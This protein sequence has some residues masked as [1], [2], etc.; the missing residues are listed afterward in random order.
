[1]SD[2]PT[3]L[4]DLSAVKLALM[5][6]KLRADAQPVLR[7]DPIAVVG[8][9]VRAPG[10]ATDP[11]RLWEVLRTGVDA[12]GDV[13]PD[14]WDAAAWYDPDPAAPGKTITRQG[15]FLPA[16]DGFDAGYFGIVPREA[17]RMDPQ[18]RLVLEI[19]VEAL[20]DAG[21]TR[22]RL[23]GA[24][25][26]VFVA[27]YHN[28]YAQRQY[29]DVEEIDARTLT[30]TLHS[31]L[32]NR[33]SFVL[34]LH[35][36][37]VS[38]DSACSS[39]LVAIHLAC[40]SLRSGET[41]LALAG[42]VS[43]II[44]PEL[45]VSMSKVGFMAPDG[46]C[47]TF[48]ARADGFGRGEGC[49]LVV[50]KRLSDAVADGDRVL[51][52][53]RGSAVNQDGTSTLLAAPNGVAQRALIAEALRN[54]QLDPARIGFV[55]C[56]GTGTALGD[57]LEVE[58]IAA[59]VGA[60]APG[61]GPCWLSATKANVGHL[62]AAAGA[63][64]LVKAVLV[65]RH[66][67]IPQQVHY[68]QLNPHIRLEGTRLAIASE[69]VPWPAGEH[70]RCGGVSSFGV[71]GTNAH[72]VVEEAPRLPGADEPAPD[73]A[74]VL[75]LS[76]HGPE[77]LRALAEAWTGF[78]PGAPDPVADLCFTAAERRTHH[79]LRLA[80]VGRTPDE[81]RARLGE[82][83][84][85]AG[86]GGPGRRSQ[87]AP[88]I[89]FVFSGQGPQWWAMG[90]ELLASEPV[91]RER[92]EA[93]DG[94]LRARTGWSL[95]EELSRDEADSLLGETEIAQPALFALQVALAALWRS[96]GI[97]PAAVVGHSVGEIA[98]LHVAG[99][100]SLP[101]AVRVVAE[102]G[103]I[104][105]AATGLG[106]MAQVALDEAGAAEAV[107]PSG[108][109]LSVAALNGPRSAV[110]SGD[111]A[112]LE[113]TLAA[114]A[115]R[116]V[117][118]Q[119][120][121]VRYA[122]HSAQMAPFQRRLAEALAGLPRS[123]PSV[124]V[125]STVTGARADGEA[126]DGAYFG[127]NVREAVRFAPAVAAMA[128][129]G[130]DAFLELSPHPVLAGAVAETLDAAGHPAPV[131]SSLRRQ[132]PERETML[133]ACA[134]LWEAGASPAWE[135]VQPS[136]GRVVSLPAYP[137]QRRRFWLRP[138]PAGAREAAPAGSHPILGRR[139]EA[140]GIR[141][142]VFE[143]GWDGTPAW[144]ADHRVYGRLILP[145]A[146][147]LEGLRAAAQAVLGA[148]ARELRGFAMD[149]PLAL[150]EPGAG[151]A[152]W[153][154]VV[155]PGA[156]GDAELALYE[157]APGGEGAAAWRRVASA[158][159]APAATP[160]GEAT[161]VAPPGPDAEA[162]AAD[163][164][165]DR[166]AALGVAFGPAFRPLREV[167]RG[168][169]AAEAWLDLPPGTDAGPADAL[170]P[171]LLDGALQLASLAAARGDGGALPA[172]VMLPV[173]A[174]R[175]RFGA[176]ARGPLR[177][178]ARVRA[179]TPG[180]SLVCDLALET[181]GGEAVATVEGMRF[182]AA[183]PEALAPPE[184]DA[185]ALYG[186][187]WR[188]APPAAPAPA[189]APGRWVV[190]CDRGG[191]GDA[192]AAELAAAGATCVRV[193]AGAPSGPP[194]DGVLH[195]D[196][197]DPMQ[198][199]S[200]LADAGA[201]GALVHLWSLDVP[202]LATAGA[203]G[204]DAAAAQPA[205]ELEPERL[206]PGALLHLVQALAGREGAAPAL[207]VVTRGAQVVTGAEPAEA[208]RPRAAGAWGLAAVAAVEHP[209]L[210][211]RAV[212]LDP[213]EDAGRCA[214]LARELLAGAPAARVALRGGARLV[215]ELERRPEAAA[216]APQALE[217]VQP[218][219][220][221]G[222]ALRPRPRAPLRAG[223]VRLRVLAAG[224]NFR[225]VLLT[226][227]MYPGTGVPLGAECAGVVT[228]VGPG[229]QGLAPGDRAFG[230]APGSLATEAV[231]PAAF[232]APAPAS[233]TA[234]E[235]AATPVAF[236]TA[237]YGFSRLARLR[238]G[239]KVLV[240]AAAGGVGLAAVQLAQRAGA[241]VFATA[242]SPEKRAL[243]A[244]LGVKH[245]MDSRSLAFADE[246]RA[247]TGGVGVDVVL[248]S[249][250]GDFIAASLGVLAKG[251]RFLE[252]GKR[253]ILTPE[254]AARLRPDVGYHAYDLGAEAL[255]DPG[256]L[257]PMMDELLAAFAKGELRPLPVKVFPLDRA[258]EAFRFMAQALHVGKIV[259]RPAGAV[260][261]RADATYLVTGGL[262]G[263]GLET[264]RWLARS[265]ARHL[266]LTGRRAPG[267]AA[268]AA[269]AEL[270]AAGVSVRTVAAD[271]ADP[272]A[273][274]SL[275]GELR[276]GAAPLR[277]VFHAAGTVDDGVLVNQTWERCR[278]VLRGKADGAYLLHALTRDAGLELFVLYSAASLFL[279]AP[280]QG[281]YPAA[282]AELDALA[283][284]RRRMGLPALSV[285]W[286][287]WG[288]AGMAADP[289]VRDVWAGRGLA[290]L[291][292]DRGFAGLEQLLASGAAHGAVLL[293]DWRRFAGQLSAG[294]DR[295]FFGKLLA[296]A[297][298]APAPSQ[299]APGG[300]AA[301]LAALPAAQRL[302]ALAAQ[303]AERV[304]QILGLDAVAAVDPKVALKELGLD[305]LMAV[306]LRNGLARALGKP[307][308]AT[309]VFDHPTLEALS[310][311]LARTRGL[312]VDAAAPEPAAAART[313]RDAVAA[314]SDAE[315]EA[316]LLAELEGT[317]GKAQ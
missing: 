207:W 82:R 11:E 256:L 108:G 301:A 154:I 68:R 192:L 190:L 282:N 216:G 234:E 251:G 32:A 9:A 74:R 57:P 296:A 31:V 41:D 106:R 293:V 217:L 96:W 312:E 126:F 51:A 201:F 302:P 274:G 132:K 227:G 287:L 187:A 113:E 72:V 6:Q 30:G 117:S 244:S 95:L 295:A 42:G 278:A 206:G 50:L 235:A 200:V 258:S 18:Q 78:L 15:A 26:G 23:R 156:G 13:P 233:M 62:E 237:H 110:L 185:G 81:L 286:G 54:A 266:V 247:A 47:K 189:A 38:V 277:G 39:S 260:L 135:V 98:A 202:P 265:G 177:A 133:A 99:V 138:R 124:P 179:E 149:R 37:S 292:P 165:Y 159:V 86:P 219:T 63:L 238:A 127:R 198:L 167:R 162:V 48:D 164:V 268:Q 259:L 291:A 229:V 250:A 36:P 116:G 175:A 315:A 28:D 94:L 314:L 303:V 193:R 112:A 161:A 143:A 290:P 3:R 306:E 240:H 44:V 8:M 43:L 114:L 204:A 231:V 261:V 85:D 280:G 146:A 120:L 128:A 93:V 24:R 262:G 166:F 210:R 49:A 171:V 289:A 27:S 209:E 311:H 64:G 269:V 267:A 67:A 109:R 91:F 144:L 105:Q 107:R 317:G 224:V 147:A 77:A 183:R 10:G 245:V 61:A 65:L 153:Q 140:A 212:D 70:P 58:A 155:T 53:V 66:G 285:A 299:A 213:A 182:A 145:A 90:R 102:R 148:G 275:V 199:R 80:V 125:Y 223:E 101:D 310:A 75:P 45:L 55:E 304:R 281:A 225:D 172:G 40:E 160:A 12:V 29:E 88:R 7:A 97:A 249:L 188:S 215:P 243:L 284:A 56:H 122:F 218:G 25:A 2:G 22:E 87:K 222:V 173:G 272:A 313:V 197:A 134:A 84:R 307:L 214:G 180:A 208:L 136:P 142:Q 163:A 73:V 270:A 196:P 178:R 308:P 236:L 121:P 89:A 141:E 294:A 69:L 194:E 131:V 46:R 211:V 158:S 152:R 60:P 83:L 129:D 103:K 16:I 276:A 221:D 59:T 264:A 254:A 239:E 252:L 174:D 118:H 119:L 111:T 20:D 232:L 1:M 298:P 19:A 130:L 271:A 186:I 248:N 157:A 168:D 5:A 181:E 100:L 170:H 288:G 205:P 195:A 4:G 34:D 137:W 150:P 151:R 228:E 300:I 203:P 242:G 230:F 123:A 297:A 104:M 76:A 226:L 35:G 283:Q 316:A 273:M 191:A 309:L 279:G 257:R 92:L 253:D 71:G 305:S 33:I 176:P 184:K 169:G 263:I 115:A 139:V 17:E 241:E 255:A 21:L 79:D 52:V 246:V 220:L 14:R